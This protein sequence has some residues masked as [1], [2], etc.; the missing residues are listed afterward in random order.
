MKLT[1]SNVGRFVAETE[2]E[3]NGI[4]VIAGKNGTGKSTI[5]KLLYCIFDSLYKIDEQIKDNRIATI[6]RIVMNYFVRVSG[7][8]ESSTTRREMYDWAPSI[9][10]H[11]AVNEGEAELR[12]FLLEL[13][14]PFEQLEES[15]QNSFLR[16]IA[17]ALSVTDFTILEELTASRFNAEFGEFLKHVNYSNIK[18]EVNLNIHNQN[19]NV[20]LDE[21]MDFYLNDEFE[22][23]KDMVYLDD[24]SSIE[25]MPFYRIMMNYDNY[26]H[27][28]RLRNK[29]IVPK[30]EDNSALDRILAEQRY[31][32]II[33]KMDEIAIGDIEK[34]KNGNIEYS[35]PGLKS[36]ISMNNVSAGTRVLATIKKLIINGYIDEHGMIVLDEPEVHLHPEWQMALAE[37]IVLMQTELDI[38]V[39]IN[40]HSADF[41]AFIQYYS[42]KYNCKEKCRYYHAIA[43]NKYESELVD[44]SNDNQVLFNELGMP[45]VRVTEETYE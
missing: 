16:E 35:I 25:D 8:K 33:A 41:V 22:I 9:V 26:G 18:S 3:I 38:N 36:R 7:R 19:I 23:V 14:C 4:T 30:G 28:Y 1:F 34:G 43:A 13:G 2:V 10:K 6:Q 32:N 42:L 37:M 45:F 12:N 24:L 17:E 27:N 39:L 11:Y 5:S 20:V 29:I 15:V 21:K 31:S 40:T 44:V